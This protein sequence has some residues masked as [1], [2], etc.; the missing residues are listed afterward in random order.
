MPDGMYLYAFICM[1][2]HV[3][4]YTCMYVSSNINEV[5]RD[6]FRPFFRKRFYTQK[7]HK[8]RK[9]QTSDFHS[10]IFIRLKQTSNLLINNIKSKQTFTHK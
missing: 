4:L 5:I 2:V 3:C 9:I 6:N 7:K 8:K 10:D 1:I